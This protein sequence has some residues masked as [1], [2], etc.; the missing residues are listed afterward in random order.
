MYYYYYIG[1][2]YIKL[3]VEISHAANKA[4]GQHIGTILQWDTDIY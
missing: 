1:Q 3:S 4:L 2:A